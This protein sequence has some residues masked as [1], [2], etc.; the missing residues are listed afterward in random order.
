VENALGSKWSYLYDGNGNLTS[1]TDA[2]GRTT[3]YAYDSL[4]RV[5]A[6]NWIGSDGST[7]VRTIAYSYND[8]DQLE[9]ISDPDSSYSYAYDDAGRVTSIDNRLSP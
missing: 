9:S 2:D 4:D 6:E 7:I 3:R 5:T 8:K 1:T